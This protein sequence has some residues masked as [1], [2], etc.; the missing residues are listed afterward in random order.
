MSK[1]ILSLI[2]VLLTVTLSANAQYSRKKKPA[3]LKGLSVNGKI[4]PNIFCGDIVDNGRWRFGLAASADKEFLEWLSG[5]VELEGGCFAGKQEG[6]ISFKT[7]FMTFNTGANIFPLNTRG[8]Y[9]ERMFDPYGGLGFGLIMFGAKKSCSKDLTEEV[10]ELDDWRNIK[11]GFKAAP[12]VYGLVGCKYLLPVPG[13]HWSLNLEI[14]AN[15]PFSDDLDGHTGYRR[16]YYEEE[17]DEIEG[18]GYTT[19]DI[20]DYEQGKWIGGKKDFFYT[21]MVGCIYKFERMNWK[22]AGKYNRK[23]YLKNRKTYVKNQKR[24]KRR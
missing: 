21:V 3:I 14:K 16:P 18:K 6:G 1:Y 7:T 5:R 10:A 24:S 22:Q 20:A 12:Y 15:L 11:T 23:V 19:D 17:I 2:V 8:F 4:G 13:N 9:R